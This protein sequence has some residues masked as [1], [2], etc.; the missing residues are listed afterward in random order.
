[1]KRIWRYGDRLIQAGFASVQTRLY[2]RERTLNIE[3]YLG[4]LNTY[5]DHRALPEARRRA[6]NKK[7]RCAYKQPAVRSGS[8]IR[9]ISISRGKPNKK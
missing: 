8:M 7:W 6:L 9:L 5:S 4:L 3:E 2:H 1:M